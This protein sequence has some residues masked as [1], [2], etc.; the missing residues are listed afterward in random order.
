MKTLIQTLNESKTAKIVVTMAELKKFSK[1]IKELIQHGMA[2]DFESYQKA[3]LTPFA[4]QFKHKFE[5]VTRMNP[6]VLNHKLLYNQ[7]KSGDKL[8]FLLKSINGVI[9][10]ASKLNEDENTSAFHRKEADFWASQLNTA[11]SKLDKRAKGMTSSEIDEKQAHHE[12]Q[13]EILKKKGK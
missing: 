7:A 2:T 10:N 6:E 1:E 11:T 4:A 5:L 3:P 8:E 9:D 12:R 13:Y